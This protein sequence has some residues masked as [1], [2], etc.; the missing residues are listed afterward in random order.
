MTSNKTHTVFLERTYNAETQTILNFF[1]D[2]TIFKLTGADDIQA[3]FKTN[4][5]FCLAFNGRG[6]IHGRFIKITDKEIIMEWNV[7]GFQRPEEIKTLV[8]IYI[9]GDNGKCTL[10]LNHKNI[11]HAEAAAAK[12]RAWTEILDEIEHKTNNNR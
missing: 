10:A 1:K 5:L 8:E 11:V 2:T 6:T 12:Q 4:G 9:Y 7:D 3:D